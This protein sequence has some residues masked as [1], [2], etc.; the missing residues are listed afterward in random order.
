M[1][2]AHRKWHRRTWLVL[3]PLLAVVIGLALVSRVAEPVNSELPAF[4]VAP[5]AKQGN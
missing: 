5:A 4:L 1:K 2:R 3:A